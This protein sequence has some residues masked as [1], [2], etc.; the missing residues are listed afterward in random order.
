[1]ALLLALIFLVVPIA[2]L[3]VIVAVA[4]SIGVFNTLGLLIAVSLV[5][6]WLAKRE[7]LSII[8][9]V[10]AALD[11]GELPSREVADGFLILFAGA[12][13]LAPGF[14]TDVLAILLLL[15][16]TRAVIRGAL[17]AYAVR[18]GRVAVVSNYGGRAA[19]WGSDG[20][21]DAESW[22]EAPGTPRDR[23]PYDGRELGGKA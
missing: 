9:R 11:R 8:T 16:P 3:A 4:Q 15:P 6:A 2:E 12:L 22:E 13:M 10:R 17:V 7:G 20:V 14:I 21:W 1:M 5:G 19:R 18:R 23:D